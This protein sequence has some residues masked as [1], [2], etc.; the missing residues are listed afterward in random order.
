[1]STAETKA[2]IGRDHYHMV[3]SAGKNS[4]IGDEPESKGGK[5]E[6]MNPFEI[7]ASALGACTCAT[8][9]MYADRKEMR[10][11]AIHVTLHLNRDDEKNETT[12][13]RDIEFV[14]D[15]SPEERDR[16][17]VIANKCPIHKT[18]TNPIHIDTQLT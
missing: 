6:G 5:E 12:I 15:L 4:F 3:L 17:L 11:E 1:M 14:G 8:V 2:S 9:R 7:L 16:L 10:L 18:L 13:K